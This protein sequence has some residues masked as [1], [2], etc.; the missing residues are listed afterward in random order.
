M[1][2]HVRLTGAFSV[3]SHFPALQQ[4]FAGCVMKNCGQEMQPPNRSVAVISAVI[5]ELAIVLRTFLKNTR[6]LRTTPVMAAQ[7]SR[8]HLHR[9]AA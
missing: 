4:S 1:R 6:T 8:H 7:E 9:G 3:R 2:W 5:S